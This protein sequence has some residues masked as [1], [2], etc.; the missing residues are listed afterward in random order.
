MSNEGRAVAPLTLAGVLA[1]AAAIG[2][3]GP[4]AGIPAQA[5]DETIVRTFR[6]GEGARLD[7]SNLAGDIN[8]T[9]VDGDELEIRAT[10]RSRGRRNAAD[11]VQIDFEERASGVV[12]RTYP[13]GGEGRNARVDFLVR[14]P[15]GVEAEIQ[16][17][18]G[19]ITAIGVTGAFRGQSVSGDLTITG[20]GALDRAE[21]VS[22]DLELDDIA[23]QGPLYLS[24]VSGDVSAR[25]LQAPELELETVSGDVLLSDAAVSRFRLETVSG[26]VEYRG[27]LSAGGRYDF[28]SHSGDVLLVVEGG[29]RL[30]A[31][32]FSGN[33]RPDVELTVEPGGAFSGR[34]RQRALSG[35]HGDGGAILNVTTFSGNLYLRQP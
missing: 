6:L 24:S 31:E 10:I 34:D 15:G 28:N 35:V 29:F 8:V 32:T 9:G 16:T 5:D 3:S 26:E 1:L 20:A 25:R 2:A 22:G 11:Q 30:D 12:V 7:L 23:S 18:S 17:V 4:A 27:A 21:T 14:L 13:R 19:D 33:L